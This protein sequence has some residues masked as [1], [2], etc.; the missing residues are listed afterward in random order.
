MFLDTNTKYA[1]SEDGNKKRT[2]QDWCTVRVNGLWIYTEHVYTI[3]IYSH[4]IMVWNA[5]DLMRWNICIVLFMK[6]FSNYLVYL[7]ASFFE[8]KIYV[9]WKSLR[10]AYI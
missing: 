6:Y 7:S 8:T 2:S 5:D 3:N 10:S 9:V 1:V 4:I